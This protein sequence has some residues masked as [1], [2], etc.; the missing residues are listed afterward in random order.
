[1][2]GK[3]IFT[4]CFLTILICG[5]FVDVCAEEVYRQDFSGSWTYDGWTAHNPD[6]GEAFEWESVKSGGLLCDVSDAGAIGHTDENYTAN[7][8]VA[9]PSFWLSSEGNYNCSFQQRVGNASFPENM[10]TYIW[11]GNPA[12]FDIGSA[13]LI[14]AGGGL[15][16]TACVTRS[17][18]FTVST[19]GSDYHVIFYCTSAANQYLAIWDTLLV[20]GSPTLVELTSFIGQGFKDHTLLTWETSSEIDNAGFHLWRS[21]TR[22]GSYA[23]ITQTLIPAEAGATWGATYSYTD[24]DVSPP[25]AWYYKLEDISNGGSSTFHGPVLGVVGDAAVKVVSGPTTIADG[26]TAPGMGEIIIEGTGQHTVTTGRYTD[27]PAL[28]PAFTPT[29]YYGFVDVIDLSGLNS[30]KVR[31]CPAAANNTVYYWNG[32]GWVKCSQQESTDGCMAVTLTD[33]TSPRISELTNLVFAMGSQSA[34]IPTLSEWGMIILCILMAVTGVVVM[35]S[36][37]LRGSGVRSGVKS[38]L[39][40]Y[41]EKHISAGTTS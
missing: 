23:R 21:E 25:Q 26:D 33:T 13:I 34:P 9:S 35:R 7:T 39:G 1:M 17:N 14:W 2:H 10:S 8:W 18:N 29:G 22:N 4:T 5:L 27:N 32:S 28:A 3:R 31:F 12:S 24:T 16:N 30:V 19:T 37:G 15:V 6:H 38:L 11:K 20:S 40:S 36:R 41:S